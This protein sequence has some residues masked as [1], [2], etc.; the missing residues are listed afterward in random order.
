M[1]CIE[2]LDKCGASCCKYFTIK[3]HLL[4][5]DEIEYYKLHNCKVERIDRNSYLLIISA[6]CNALTEDNKCKLHDGAKPFHC[7]RLDEKTK[8]DYYITNN[9]VLK[10]NII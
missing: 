1:N 5:N 8:G 2:N 9:C 7:K 3:T 4:T 10:I 6:K